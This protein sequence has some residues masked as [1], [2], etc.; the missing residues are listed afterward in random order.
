MAKF[1][2]PCEGTITSTFRPSHRPNHHGIDIAKSGTVPIV[3]V[4][5]GKVSRSYVSSTY[6]EVVFIVHNI[7]GET[8][9]TVYAHMRSGSRKVKEGDVVKQGQVIGYMGNTG[10]STGQHLHFELHKGRWNVNKTNAVDPMKYLPIGNK[11]TNTGTT[12]TVARNIDKT[13]GIGVATVK[14]DF[15]NL[16]EGPG[17]QYKIK[18]VLKKGETYYVYDIKDGWYNLGGGWASNVGNKYMVFRPH[19]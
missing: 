13:K 19:K 11:S 7:D 8:W 14:V 2:M 9:E 6:G 1:I 5:D 15:L 18:K 3:A 16:R 4:A 12:T 10:R 17:T